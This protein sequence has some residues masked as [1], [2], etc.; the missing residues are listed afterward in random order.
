KPCPLFTRQRIVVSASGAEQRK[1]SIDIGSQKR[2][3]SQDR[4]VDVTL[5]GKMNQGAR[6]VLSQQSGYEVGVADVSVDKGICGA[7]CHRREIRGVPGI[8]GPIEIENGPSASR[9]PV[10]H[11]IGTDKSGTTGYDNGVRSIAF[12][13]FRRLFKSHS[14]TN[15]ST[16]H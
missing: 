9:K 8:G 1:G 2:L 7:R 15:A 13:L 10:Q 6:S 14:S 11:K 5:C 12:D 4:A 16:L 3:R